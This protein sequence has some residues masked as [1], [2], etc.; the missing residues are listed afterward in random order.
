MERRHQKVAAAAAAIAGEHAT[1]AIGAVS[2]RREAHKEH[3]SGRI[4][5]AW[6]RPAPVRLVAIRSTFVAGN[7]PTIRT[8]AG[9]VLAS[10][11]RVVNGRE[12]VVNVG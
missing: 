9:T 8:K 7:L 4:A 2:R 6:H 3:A 5:E 11:N 10:D 12:A 1:C